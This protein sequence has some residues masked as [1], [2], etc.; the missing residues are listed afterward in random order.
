MAFTHATAQRIYVL[1]NG[2][3]K[4]GVIVANHSRFDGVTTDEEGNTQRIIKGYCMIALDS[5]P[6]HAQAWPADLVY[7][8]TEE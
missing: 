7:V 4:R 3:P 5:D 8:E 1:R 6:C 2:Y